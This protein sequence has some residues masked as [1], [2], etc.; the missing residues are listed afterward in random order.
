[1]TNEIYT[2]NVK[3]VK[4]LESECNE[5]LAKIQS[6]KEVV[7][8]HLQLVGSIQHEFDEFARRVRDLEATMH[9]EAQKL[10]TQ[11]IMKARVETMVEFQRG[12]WSL[13][14]VDDTI[15]IYNAAYP[16]DAFPVGVS[17]GDG[18]EQVPKP[19]D[20]ALRA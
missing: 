12:E 6:L 18:V 9:D 7:E 11:Q 3:L 4:E 15:K 2:R 14:D 10:V 19:V 13:S 20:D 5:C 17:D 8:S 1:M 16:E